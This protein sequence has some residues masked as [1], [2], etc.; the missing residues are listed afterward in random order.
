MKKVLSIAMS[1]A[2]MLSLTLET[3]AVTT[4]ETADTAETTE[5]TTADLVSYNGTI[6]E[7]PDY[8]EDSYNENEIA[9]SIDIYD[10]DP[11]SFTTINTD[12]TKTVEIFQTPIKYVEDEE[13]KFIDTKLEELSI[14]NKLSSEYIYEC[15]KAPVKSFFPT[16]IKDGISITN[17]EYEIK[18]SP[19]IE[20][21]KL[22]LKDIFSKS[23][24]SKPTLDEEN[25]LSYEDVFD[26]NDIITYTPVST[27]VKEEIIIEEY[28]GNNI[29]EFTVELK[30]LEPLYLSGDSIPLIDKS[31]GEEVAA[32]SQIDMRDSS[33]G[34]AFNTSL[35]NKIEL[36]KIDGDIYNLK[37]IL[38]KEFL[39][40]ETTVYPVIVDPTITF[41]SSCIY[42]APVFSGYPNTNNNANTYNVVG[43]HG[44]SYGE[45]IAFIKI[46]NIQ[47]YIYINP[48]NITSAYLKVYEGSGKTSSATVGVYD[49][50]S[51]WN[52]TTITY[53]NMPSLN[54]IPYTSITISSSNWY[55]FSIKGFIKNWLN[56]ALQ[57]G[58][59]SQNYGLALKMTTTGVSSRHFCS[60]NH[61]TYPSSI[62][63]NY[64]EDTSLE[65]G[66]YFI[67]SAYSGLFLDTELNTTANGN[68]IQYPA[69][70][71]TNQ[72]WTIER[73]SNGYYILHSK[74][75]NNI[76]SLGISSNSPANGTNVSVYTD[77]SS[78]KVTFRII[79]NND[80][81]YRIL[82]VCNS[83]TYGLDVCGPS[84]T[85]TANIQTWQYLGATQQ[86]WC[87]FKTS[88]SIQKLSS[89]FDDT[90]YGISYFPNK[91]LKICIEKNDD[92]QLTKTRLKYHVKNAISDWGDLG[93]SC[94]FVNDSTNCNIYIK[95][96][97][98]TEANAL[99]LD[100]TSAGAT[101]NLFITNKTAG[102]TLYEF[103]GYAA[104][105]TS[106]TLK[107][108]YSTTKRTIYIIWDENIGSSNTSDFEIKK[109]QAVINHEIGHAL[110][111]MGHTDKVSL[112]MDEINNIYYS[113]NTSPN[114]ANIN[115]LK[116]VY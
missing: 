63:I 54:A 15:T 1:I 72:I 19:N 3:F 23:I 29:Y 107:S 34:E 27:G 26:N 52:N 22:K 35:F 13:I 104:E 81:T 49:T 75:Y 74:Y 31:T 10:E 92:F 86:R 4:N 51:T 64:T 25:I 108:V 90:G 87:F 67:S 55:N 101:M 39:T 58:G 40:A 6:E 91:H 44:S 28:N 70:G 82:S 32:I 78:N 8:I 53:N 112:M 20:N 12:R 94:S 73:L 83:K 45:G 111:Y 61:S 116:Q 14:F 7:L 100:S 89:W 62:I 99:E 71:N 47:N 17:D 105:I 50:K 80:S 95:G 46:N 16:H 33:E 79:K 109:W 56:N 102:N 96:I 76:D 36:S 60:A 11:F 113:G 30:D 66:E 65:P 98:R 57:D 9:E 37:I 42:D 77:T 115:H 48:N 68:V 5:T 103:E 85:A 43:Y 110:G 2:I 114:T 84:T 38:D 24:F 21:Q 93:I 18:C 97:T 69:T 41:T 106:G 88:Q 59:K